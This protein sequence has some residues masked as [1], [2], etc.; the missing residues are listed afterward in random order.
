MKNLVLLGVL[1][2]G[3]CGND[4]SYE[5][6]I[7]WSGNISEQNERFILSYDESTYS[8][9]AIDQ[10]ERWWLRL[11][12]CVSFNIDITGNPLVLEY[13]DI[14]ELPPGYYG[15]TEWVDSY[16]RIYDDPIYQGLYT[17]HEMLHYLLYL[18]GEPDR[19]N[20]AHISVY[21]NRCG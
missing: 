17:R 21:F 14:S 16:I 10:H 7:T 2:L 5:P 3:G 8:G 9:V 20:S 19:N 18:M 13:T 11:Q 6:L 1:L 4:D 12:L 15:W